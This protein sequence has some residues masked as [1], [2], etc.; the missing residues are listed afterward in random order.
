M[1]VTYP[2]TGPATASPKADES[3]KDCYLLYFQYISIIVQN[4]HIKL[5]VSS[6]GKCNSLQY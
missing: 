1:I 3:Q 5:S 4:V 2:K 6:T